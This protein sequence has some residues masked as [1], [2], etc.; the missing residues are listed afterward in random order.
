MRES[1]PNISIDVD[2]ASHTE[3]MRCLES[4]ARSSTACRYTMG[5]NPK[6][7]PP[8]RVEAQRSAAIRLYFILIIVQ[9]FRF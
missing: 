6:C 3:T 8:H 7:R 4:Y 2:S 5:L 9:N 1:R